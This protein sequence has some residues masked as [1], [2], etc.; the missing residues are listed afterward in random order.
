MNL[1][2]AC[3]YLSQALRRAVEEHGQPNSFGCYELEVNY[4][5]PPAP[6]V[7][8]IGRDRLYEHLGGHDGWGSCPTYGGT[9]PRFHV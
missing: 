7:G 3:E 5:G 1:E 4:G 9:P 8:R 2:T 6:L